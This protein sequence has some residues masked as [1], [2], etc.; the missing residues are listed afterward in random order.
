VNYG[1]CADSG[2]WADNGRIVLWTCPDCQ[3]GLRIIQLTVRGSAF[4]GQ[5]VSTTTAIVV[6]RLPPAFHDK[7]ALSA[8]LSINKHIFKSYASE[9]F[10]G[11]PAGFNVIAMVRFLREAILW[12]TTDGN[13]YK[14]EPCA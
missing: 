10:A 7:H 1:F 5:Y 11:F 9:L 2:Q 14:I 3:E 8:Y 12:F 6:H 13:P 4:A